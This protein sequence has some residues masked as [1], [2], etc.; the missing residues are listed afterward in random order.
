MSD[1]GFFTWPNRTWNGTALFTESGL[2]DGFKFRVVSCTFARIHKSFALPSSFS[3]EQ[4]VVVRNENDPT[5]LELTTHNYNIYATISINNVT[6]T[7]DFPTQVIL[8]GVSVHDP[9]L[10]VDPI[11]V[12]IACTYG[13]IRLNDAFI[14]LADFTSAK[15]CS[16]N[17]LKK[18]SSLLMF[19]ALPLNLESLLN[20]LTYA[21]TVP[22]VN[23][24]ITITVYDGV[25]GP[26]LQAHVL[27]GG[28]SH[29]KGCLIT[30]QQFNVTTNDFSVVSAFENGRDPDNDKSYLPYMLSAVALFI[31]AFCSM[32]ACQCCCPHCLPHHYCCALLSKVSPMGENGPCDRDDDRL[33]GSAK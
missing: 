7:G 6:H 9:D 30:E 23:D 12:R 14:G 29:T 5:S 32:C 18:T 26:C 10:G 16:N 24:Y 20:G 25:G 19:V 2:E 27:K 33:E 15:Y 8:R 3:E 1:A 28:S 13:R 21:S 4:K 31:L 11:L 22:R 17:C